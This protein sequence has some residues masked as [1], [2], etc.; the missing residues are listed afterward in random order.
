MSDPAPSKIPVV[1]FYGFRGGDGGISHVM[2]NLMNATV[3]L[4]ATVHLLLNPTNIPELK[5]VDPRIKIFRLGEGGSFK[6]LKTL[7]NYLRVERPDA[8]LCNR[9]RANR[10]AILARM[11]ARS[12]VK[13]VI[14]VGMAISVALERRSWLKRELR[15]FGIVFC[16]RRADVVIANAE[17]VAKDIMDVTGLPREGLCVLENPTVSAE[18]LEQAKEPV[19]HPWLTS[20]QPPVVIGVGRLAR[21][22]D[23]PTLLKAFALLRAERECRLLILGEGKERQ[24]LELLAAELGIAKDVDLLGFASN[25]F[26]YMSRSSLFVLS[27]AWEGSPNVLIQALALGVPS[28]STDCPGGAKE[29]LADG[30]F[31]P[32]VPVGDHAALF[33]AMKA[34]LDNPL[35]KDVLLAGAEPFR[36][37]R[38]AQ[39]YLRA[40]GLD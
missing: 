15:R 19:D 4:G 29:I 1:A 35:P 31:G 39:A 30:K 17:G 14:R 16:Y 13:V 28:V 12:P 32:L 20:G 10:T 7:A 37:D 3:E 5:R 23:F 33:E 2:L 26:Q 24:P 36:A 11:L 27:S 25:P 18:M 38:C 21:Q 6:R 8:L 9:E 34:T 22:K 40:M